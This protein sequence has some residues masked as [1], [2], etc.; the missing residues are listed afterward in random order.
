M[1]SAWEVAKSAQEARWVSVGRHNRSLV[2]HKDLNVHDAS[3]L[4]AFQR[5]QEVH[6]KR[7]E[8]GSIGPASAGKLPKSGYIGSVSVSEPPRKPTKSS[9]A[10]SIGPV[11]VLECLQTGQVPHTCLRASSGRAPGGSGGCS[12]KRL[13]CVRFF[14][15][16]VFRRR[17]DLD[18]YDHKGRRD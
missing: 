17:P 7:P 15:S 2:P 10:R 5:F 14:V 4:P 9:E 3:A 18:R 1:R 12:R 11:D 16:L 6:P 8:S 13:V